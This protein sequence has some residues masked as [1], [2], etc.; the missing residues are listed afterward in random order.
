[1][2]ITCCYKCTPETGRHPGCHATCTRYKDERVQIDLENEERR[3][4]RD[5]R[6]YLCTA[7]LSRRDKSVKKRKSYT[8]SYK[9]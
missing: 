5:I 2:R 7:E 8:W 1:M 6:D 3:K 4:E 9:K